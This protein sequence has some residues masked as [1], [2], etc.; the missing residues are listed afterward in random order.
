MTSKTT[1]KAWP[2]SVWWTKTATRRPTNQASA[3]AVSHVARQAPAADEQQGE[4]DEGERPEREEVV[5]DEDER[6]GVVGEQA[7]EA[8]QRALRGSRA[9]RVERQEHE[10][11]HRDDDTNR[12]A[13]SAARALV[14]NTTNERAVAISEV[15]EQGWES[16]VQHAT[17]VSGG[18]YTPFVDAGSM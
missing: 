7:E 15:C 1:E 14:G 8:G 16:R 6:V 4:G 10:D 5:E 17:G 18:V 13:R 11:H 9:V 2:R 12:V 3:P